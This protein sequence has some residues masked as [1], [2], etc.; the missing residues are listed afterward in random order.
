[1]FNSKTSHPPPAAIKFGLK[2]LLYSEYTGVSNN[3]YS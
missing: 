2:G 3:Y 1:M